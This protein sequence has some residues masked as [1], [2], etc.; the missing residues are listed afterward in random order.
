MSTALPTARRSGLIFLVLGATLWGFGGLL[1][2]LLGRATELSPIAVAACRLGV[3]GLLLLAALAVTRRPLP[4]NP[5]AWRR[6]GVVACLAAWFQMTYFGAVAASSV[7]V[8]TLTTIGTSPVIVALLDHLTGR[9]ALDRDRVTTIGLAVC[10]LALL[11]GVPSHASGSMLLG[12]ALAVAAAAG[13]ATMTV[14]GA[15]PVAGLDPMATT[16]FGFSGGALLLLPFAAA[17]APTF[18][19]TVESLILLLALGLIPTA[20]AYT[21]YF[22]GLPAA[23]S[24]IAAVMALL[25]PLT[26]AILAAIVLG[27]RLTPAGLVG[28]GLLVLA[29]LLAA[30]AK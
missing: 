17:T 11:V 22:K 2:S 26:G 7:S 23:G 14:V 9:R 5:L 3:G 13:F 10:G 27:E 1:G 19:V 25:E 15:K 20:A 8:A 30:R 21:C 28:A 24:G 4:R 29:L 12:V 16:A 18:A 6:I